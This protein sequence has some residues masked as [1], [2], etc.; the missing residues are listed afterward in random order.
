[1]L[2]TDVGVRRDAP[3]AF[4]T[5]DADNRLH[6][7][8]AGSEDNFRFIYEMQLRIHTLENKMALVLNEDLPNR[9]A[10]RRQRY[11]MSQASSSYAGSPEAAHKAATYEISSPQLATLREASQ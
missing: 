6:R 5:K 3:Q 2:D 7:L 1:M 9:Q 10:S 11:A 8:E 4:A